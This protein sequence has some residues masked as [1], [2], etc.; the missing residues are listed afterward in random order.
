MKK[1]NISSVGTILTSFFAASCC[2]GPAV[3]IVTGTSVG[4]LSRLSF[5]EPVTPY[6]LVIAFLM[7]S[8][9]FWKL[10]LKKLDCDCNQDVWTRKIARIIFWVGFTS[11]LLAVSFPKVILWIY[12]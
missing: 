4:F 1:E 9:S 5:L 12:G 8:Y 2:V 6:M 11:L 10:Y 7:L 3:F